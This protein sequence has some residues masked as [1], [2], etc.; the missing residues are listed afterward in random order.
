MRDD[1][2][3][4]FSGLCGVT[5]TTMWHSRQGSATTFPHD[6]LLTK[7]DV[8]T[9]TVPVRCCFWWTCF[10][11]FHCICTSSYDRIY[12]GS[13]YFDGYGFWTN[14]VF[15]SVFVMFHSRYQSTLIPLPPSIRPMWL[16][17]LYLHILF[18]VSK[19]WMIPRHIYPMGN[20]GRKE[21]R[22]LAGGVI[23]DVFF[24]TNEN[25]AESSKFLNFFI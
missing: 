4:Y 5:E 19:C 17:G 23:L 20:L 25:C 16:Q 14:F 15:Q 9:K 3:W 11:P 8:T 21:T 22:M 1:V 2:R 12:T 13:K 6:S 7:D 24:N 10:W 18:L